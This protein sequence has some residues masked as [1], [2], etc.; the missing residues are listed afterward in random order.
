MPRVLIDG[1]ELELAPDERLNGIQAAA[2]LGIEIPHY[3]WHPGLSVVASCRMCLVETGK[4][5]AETGEIRMLPKLVPA[6]QTPA[7][8]GTVLVTNSDKVA[9]ARAMV[10][11]DLLLRHP[12]DCPICDKAGECRLQD[13]Y[14][15]YGHE[16]RRADIKPFHSRKRELGPTVRL[17]VDRCVMCSRCVRFCREVAGTA[18]LMVRDRGAHEEID[19]FEGF[20]LKNE[21]AGNVVDLCPVG[22]LADLPFLYRQR[23]WF[24]TP[25]PHVCAG[26]ATGCSIWVDANQDR[27]HRL[28]PRENP[29]VNQ[30]WM[31][32]EGRHGWEYVH[33][34]ARRTRPLRRFD[35]GALTPTDWESAEAW[36][37]ERFRQARRP[38]LVLSPTWTVEEAYLAMRWFG[39][40]PGETQ[41]VL[42]PIPQ[43]G[44]DLHFPKR[45]G[46][47]PTASPIFTISAE[48]CPNRL[49]VARLVESVTGEA[50]VGWSEAIE[51]SAWQDVDAV[52][53]AGGQPGTSFGE[54]D[55][56]ALESVPVVVVH[57]LFGG[58]L[59]GVAGAVLPDV[60]FAEREGSYVNRNGWLQSF[61]PAVRPPAGCRSMGQIM[62][63]WLERHGLYHA[64]AVLGELAGDLSG[65]AAAAPPVDPL[66]VALEPTGSSV[67]AEQSEEVVS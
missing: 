49:G 17:F 15:E 10:E 42:G 39:D 7:T 5:D 4:L 30:Y 23:V 34:T 59:D 60:A 57:A 58:V 27:I 9:A 8:D 35:D 18:E 62:W 12:V 65:W 2:R 14:F 28:R 51:R 3:C 22:A 20:P 13:Y 50:P 19:V 32:D 61:A 25:R 24:M 41:F 63:K 53:V 21:L 40:L 33:D 46:S 6:C 64:E 36:I 44:D 43:T 37:I 26:C 31:C 1:Q 11:E 29:N 48:K 47:A 52:W 66:G 56:A 54:E 38:V 55:A 45:R 67:S 16:R